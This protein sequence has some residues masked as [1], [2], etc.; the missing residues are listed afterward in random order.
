MVC[1]ACIR[2]GVDTM[3]FNEVKKAE[4]EVEGLNREAFES[5]KHQLNG[6][7]RNVQS[8]KS[9][10]SPSVVQDIEYKLSSMLELLGVADNVSFEDQMRG[11]E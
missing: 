5:L 1:V 7:L 6:V 3:W 4:L 2:W 9:N 10:M 11:K 8:L